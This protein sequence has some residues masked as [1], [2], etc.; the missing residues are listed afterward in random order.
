MTRLGYADDEYFGGPVLN[1][2][3]SIVS[4]E[5]LLARN[6]AV[7]I[8]RRE[9]TV[10]AEI[11]ELSLLV[12]GATVSAALDVLDQRKREYFENMIELGRSHEVPE[13]LGGSSKDVFWRDMRPFC[14]KVLFAGV[15]V[16]LLLLAIVPALK[17]QLGDM[18]DDAILA[19]RA[20]PHGIWKGLEDLK[21]MPE[22]K[23]K[24]AAARLRLFIESLAPVLREGQATLEEQGLVMPERGQGPR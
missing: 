14:F 9:R 19:G 24:R 2:K 18:K 16:G 12:E 17:F 7:R 22:D 1:N 20:F 11:E 4:L 8:W 3:K 21:A 10:L 5:T 6:Y 13:P 15:V 23:Q